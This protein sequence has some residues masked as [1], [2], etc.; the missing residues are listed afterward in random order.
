MKNLKREIVCYI[1]TGSHEDLVV[2]DIMEST[3]EFTEDEIRSEWKKMVDK[4]FLLDR[5]PYFVYNYR[6]KV[7]KEYVYG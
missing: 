2:K 4:G 5:G 3:D 6:D 7:A 1:D